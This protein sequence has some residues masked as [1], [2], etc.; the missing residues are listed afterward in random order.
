MTIYSL[1][2]KSREIRQRLWDRNLNSSDLEMMMGAAD[3]TA[4]ILDRYL[5]FGSKQVE[6]IVVSVGEELERVA[7]AAGQ[8][9]LTAKQRREV[10]HRSVT[11]LT[12]AVGISLVNSSGPVWVLMKDADWQRG[13][14]WEAILLARQWERQN[15]VFVTIVSGEENGIPL[16]QIMAV[17]PLRSKIASFGLAVGETE[18][19]YYKGLIDTFHTVWHDPRPGVVLVSLEREDHSLVPGEV[20]TAR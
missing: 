17:E 20:V 19:V 10:W 12:E 14:S 4:V 2:K 5:S 3:T 8:A 16:E 9:M 7:R 15:L 11:D 13:S 1:Q 18:A 6:G